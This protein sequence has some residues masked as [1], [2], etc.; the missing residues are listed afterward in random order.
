MVTSPRSSEGKSLIVA[1]LAATT[2]QAGLN[3]VAVDADLRRPRLHRLFGLDARSGLSESL[4]EGTAEGRLHPTDIEGLSALTS[5]GLPP[6]PAQLLASPRTKELL[7]QLAEQADAVVVDSAPI[8][9]VAD[10]AVLA[11]AVDGVLL[12]LRAGKS[13]REAAQQ[14]VERLHQAGANLVG[15]VLNAVPTPDDVYYF[16]YDTAEKREGESPER[17]QL[18]SLAA[19]GDWFRQ[20]VAAL[21]HWVRRE[22]KDSHA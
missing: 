13:R 2:A 21:G 11:P 16:R 20:A 9:P 17:Q 5:G 6:D 7:Q 4:V 8:L 10:A 14:A 1:N 12:V 18:G 22:R 3:V 19:L 15:V